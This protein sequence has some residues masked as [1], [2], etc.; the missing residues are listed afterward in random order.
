MYATCARLYGAL[1]G[2]SLDALLRRAGAVDVV[3][4]DIA[5]FLAQG[6]LG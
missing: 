2:C 3:C 5:A 4:L 6:M 1:S